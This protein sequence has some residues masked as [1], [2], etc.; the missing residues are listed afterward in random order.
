[1]WSDQDQLD[2]IAEGWR[3]ADVVNN[4]E[5]RAYTAVLSD[6]RF[7]NA[8]EAEAF[9]V[10]RAREHSPLHISALRAVMASRVHTSKKKR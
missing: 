4:G 5:R 1:M 3:L 8:P 9:V 6:G 10:S 2:A 7:K